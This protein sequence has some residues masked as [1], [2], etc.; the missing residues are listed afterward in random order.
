MGIW[1]TISYI[2]FS[3]RLEDERILGR[4]GNSQC[5]L[6]IDEK[7]KMIETYDELLKFLTDQPGS[8]PTCGVVKLKEIKVSSL[9]PRAEKI[10]TASNIV[11]ILNKYKVGIEDRRRL[12]KE[13]VELMEKE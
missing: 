4:S 2:F 3:A 6:T 11:C 9:S 8:A 12:I 13:I 5:L 1:N 7:R 10:S